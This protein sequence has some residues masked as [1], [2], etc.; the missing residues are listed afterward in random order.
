LKNNRRHI[1]VGI[2]CRDLLTAKTGSK[3]Y[4]SEL[5][6]AAGLLEVD[7]ITFIQLQ[8]LFKP[9]QS[10]SIF[11]KMFKHIQFIC[12]K[13]IILPFL[14]KIYSCDILICTDY[15]LP[16][17]KFG[18]KHIV[19][20]HDAF[21][22]EYPNHYNHLWLKLFHQWAVPAVSRADTM[23]VPSNYT[24]QR[25][26]SFLQIEP[27]K[28]SVVYE[29]PKSFDL[30]ITSTENEK[31]IK[32]FQPFLLHVGALSK[33][34]NI[35]FLI[36]AFKK[37]LTSTHENWMLVLVGGLGT[38]KNDDDSIQIQQAIEEDGFNDK[39]ILVGYCSDAELTAYYSNA[40]GYIF[41]SYNEGFGL[42]LLE[43]M[44]FNLPIA[45]ANNTCLPEI[46]KEAAIYFDPYNMDETND[47]IQKIM[48]KDADVLKSISYQSA[49]L[50]QYSWAKAALEISNI[51]RGLIQ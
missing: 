44:R 33:H 29:A 49:V 35:P 31:N 19:V 28:V 47:F 11:G 20:F 18:V 25:L 50:A 34:K 30:K 26:L 4:L 39:V 16:S 45:A 15:F 6:K 27:H 42:P 12:W 17:L 14:A 22:W 21:F 36:K 8:P 40:S 48:H 38:S 7:D 37:A 51:C 2:D 5:L 32:S 24:K 3:T 10:Q 41:P 9:V 23:L 1:R 13:Q 46:G 43:A